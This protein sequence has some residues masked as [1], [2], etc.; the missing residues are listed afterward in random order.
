MYIYNWISG[1]CAWETALSVNANA[2]TDDDDD[3]QGDGGRFEMNDVI[4]Y[5]G[6]PMPHD[7]YFIFL[8]LNNLTTY[9]IFRPFLANTI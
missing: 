7:F 5:L 3:V 2:N 8:L 1:G 4:L 6:V 9:N